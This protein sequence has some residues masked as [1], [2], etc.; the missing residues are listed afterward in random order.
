MFSTGERSE[1]QAD[2]FSTQ[3]LLVL[4]HAAVIDA[5]SLH[6]LMEHFSNVLLK[7]SRPFLKWMLTEWELLLLDSLFIPFGIDRTFPDV[8][9]ASPIG[10]NSPPYH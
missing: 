7:Y 10:T 4:S 1:L 5:V 6:L 3:T 8:H 2:Q 9:V